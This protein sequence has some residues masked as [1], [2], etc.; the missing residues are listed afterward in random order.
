MKG[1]FSRVSFDPRHHFSQVL[2]QQGRVTLD[3]DPNEQ[4]AILLHHLRTLALDLFGPYAA[5]AGS[6]G[7]GLVLED[8]DGLGLQIGAG[9]YYVQG[10]LC[11]SDGCDYLAQPHYTPADGKDGP[12]DAL[13]RWLG[14]ANRDDSRFWV[15]LKVWERH[16]TS[17]EMPHLRE[18][19]LGGPDTCSRSQVV[20]QVRA[21]DLAEVDKRLQGRI[22]GWKKRIEQTD[23][24]AERAQLQARLDALVAQRDLLRESPEQ[25]CAVPLHLFERDAGATMALRLQPPERLDDPCV[26][27]PEVAYRGTENHL[28]RIEIHRGS[29]SGA[30]TFKWS[31]DNGSVVTRWISGGGKRLRVASTRG[32]VDA[33]WVELSDEGDDLDGLPGALCRVASVDGDELVLATDAPR[34]ATATSKVRRWDQQARGD[35]S[36]DEGAVPLRPSSGRED[37][38]IDLEDGLQVRFDPDGEYVSGDYWQAAVRTTGDTGWPHDG[39]GNAV[40]EAPHGIRYFHAPLGFVGLSDTGAPGVLA[41]CTCLVY[42]ASTCAAPRDP[43]DSNPSTKRDPLI[44]PVVKKTPR[45]RKDG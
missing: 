27:D 21:L 41:P 36:L 37:D 39:D 32:F 6:P 14:S 24:E 38:W 35:V 42:P 45:K 8:D 12:M 17:I 10:L 44:V 43:L 2:L 23:D 28:Y 31:R 7:F 30:P 13:R 20:W 15:Y 9:R 26:T 29:E 4:G 3:A 22:E 19:A 25:A 1:D 34:Q 5:P 18:V 33:Q 16:V 40:A 11:E